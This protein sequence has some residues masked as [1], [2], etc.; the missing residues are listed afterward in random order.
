M[1]RLSRK[2]PRIYTIFH[3]NI[4]SSLFGLARFSQATHTHTH[5]RKDHTSRPQ[6]RGSKVEEPRANYTKRPNSLPRDGPPSNESATQSRHLSSGKNH[7][8]QAASRHRAAPR[9][10]SG[11]RQRDNEKFSLLLPPFR[12]G[13]QIPA[14]VPLFISFLFSSSSQFFFPRLNFFSVFVG[15]FSF[16]F[17]SLSPRRI[18]SSE[19]RL[20]AP[21]GRSP[22]APDSPYNPPI[23]SSVTGG[24]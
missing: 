9:D 21:L 1:D 8:P 18:S 10:E 12:Q 13:Q 4:F 24:D 7:P 19:L 5:T 11:P 15:N 22:R 17:F 6:V 16:F 2:S 14:L 3:A 23:S 20:R